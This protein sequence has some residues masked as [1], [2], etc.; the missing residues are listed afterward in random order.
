[1]IFTRKINQLYRI[2]PQSELITRFEAPGRLDL[3]TRTKVKA[4]TVIIFL[5]VL[6]I[7]RALPRHAHDATSVPPPNVKLQLAKKAMS[8]RPAPER[9]GFEATVTSECRAEWNRV[10]SVDLESAI[11]DAM[12]GEMLTV[13]IARTR[14][15]VEEA[16]RLATGRACEKLPKAH[17][18]AFWRKRFVEDCAAKNEAAGPP[19][20][21]MAY[22]YYRLHILD[23][24][25]KDRAAGEISDAGLLLTKLYAAF[26]G[27]QGPDTARMTE[28][29]DRVLAL[30]PQSPAAAGYALK[31][32]YMDYASSDDGAEK[33]EKEKRLEAALLSAEKLN[34]DAD[35]TMEIRLSLIRRRKDPDLLRRT[36][37]SLGAKHPESSLPLYYLAWA[38]HLEDRRDLAENYLRALLS[39]DEHNHD[40]RVESTLQRLEA[41]DGVPFEE[42]DTTIGIGFQQTYN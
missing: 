4:V 41:P 8:G 37:L 7:L 22:V 2:T 25:T 29:A 9:P 35:S 12:H 20:C 14:P 16:R 42:W 21:L 17:P 11:V 10:T 34:P 19:R 13:D 28:L 18:L 31:A 23:E 6:P 38:A 30:D 5:V 40:P 33:A 26:M 1:M 3:M 32:H 24:S 39:K 36:A 27:E 15:V